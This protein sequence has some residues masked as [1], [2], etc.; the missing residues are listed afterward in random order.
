[1]TASHVA[2]TRPG[3]ADLHIHTAFSDGMAEARV[4][5]DHVEANTDLDVIAITDHDDIRGAWQARELWARGN[6]RFD[7]VV[8]VEVT[9]IEGHLVALYLE[10]PVPSLC[11]VEAVLE[12]VH[13]QGGLCIIAHPMSRLTRSLGWSAIRRVESRRDK[14]VSFDGIEATHRS[15]L[16]A[17][18]VHTGA[19]I[20]KTLGVAEVASSDAHFLS[21]IGSAYTEFP[22]RSAAELKA[23][24]QKDHMGSDGEPTCPEADRDR[25][26]D[27]AELAGLHSDAAGDG[28]AAYR[29]QLRPAHRS[30]AMTDTDEDRSCFAIRLGAAR[31]R[32][33]A[34]RMSG[35]AV[36]AGRT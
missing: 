3:K 12:S 18:W 33:P 16:S 29:L 10:E 25:T 21:I 4:L 9:S 31:R 30:L 20:N 26:S 11:P 13:R 17:S 14:G 24:S 8:G 35:G 34:H 19:E 22:G 7:L 27:A 15:W 32:Q 6:Y 2:E 1:M 5:L 36:R 23:A 28:L